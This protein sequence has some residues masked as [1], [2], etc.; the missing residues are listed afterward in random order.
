[1]PVPRHVGFNALFLDPSASGGVDTYLRGLVPALVQEHPGLEVTIFT[2]RRG[3]AALR[4]DGW[5]DFARLVRFPFDEGQRERRL[6]AEQA[7]IVGGALRHRVDLLHSLASTGPAFPVVPSVVTVH[8]VTFFHMETFGRVTTAGMRAVVTGAARSADALIAVAAA[9]RDE[10]AAQLGIPADRFF[11]V[12]HGAGRLPTATPTPARELRERLGLDGHRLALCVAAVRP[13]KNQQLLVEALP[14]LPD[15]VAVVLVGTQ[16]AGAAELPARAARLGVA[17][18]LHMPGYLPDADVEGLWREAACA[19]F[20]T[21]AEGFGLP[22][23]EAMR[24]GVPVACS[25]IPVLHEVGG[26]A[27]TYFSPDDPAG[28]AAAIVR[29][30]VDDG[31]AARG[32][33]RAAT[34]SWQAA[35]HGTFAA[36]ERALS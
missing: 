14:L 7:G 27:A 4:A 6:L 17:E 9:A 19:V 24:R 20:P 15:D 28:A 11:V 13:H 36:Y 3:A 18:R 12:P 35:A 10:I 33:E 1:V 31:A 34:F 32:R 30:M 23:V 2:T 16:E 29:A 8:D 5:G 21:R 22:V 25:D 26:A